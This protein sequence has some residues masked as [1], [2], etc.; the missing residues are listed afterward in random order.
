M[1]DRIFVLIIIGIFLFF[2]GLISAQ[3]IHYKLEP[4]SKVYVEWTVFNGGNSRNYSG[5]Y[6]IKGTDF[7][8]RDY[9]QSAGKYGGSYRVVCISDK[10]SW[11]CFINNQSVCIYTGMNDVQVNKI[12]VIK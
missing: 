1:K 11:G 9:W 3:I 4:E 6:I 10:D 7:Y 8:I 5:T 2:F 12:K